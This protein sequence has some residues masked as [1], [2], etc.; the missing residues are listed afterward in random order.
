MFL[1]ATKIHRPARKERPR[2]FGKVHGSHVRVVR[3]CHKGQHRD[4]TELGRQC[5]KCYQQF[6]TV[7]L[8]SVDTRISYEIRASVCIIFV[9]TCGTHVCSFLHALCLHLRVAW[10][11]Y[12]FARTANTRMRREISLMC[13][14]CVHVCV[15][16]VLHVHT[17]FARVPVCV[18][19]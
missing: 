14:S 19:G 3:D 4:C 2:L 15:F 13:L 6:R 17:R 11:V 9:Y 5:P 16:C 12:L 7:V 8:V 18:D 1:A 10:F